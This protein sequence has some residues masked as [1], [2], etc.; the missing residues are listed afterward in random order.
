MAGIV[1]MVIGFLVFIVGLFVFYTANKNDDSTTKENELSKAIEIAVADG[2]LTANEKNIIKELSTKRSLD[3]DEIIKDAEHKI[4]LQ[5]GNSETA[6][7]DPK[8]KNG[9]D[10]EKFIVQKF[11]RK[12]FRLKGWAGDKYVN[13]IYADTTSQP[14][15]HLSFNFGKQKGEFSVECK[16]RQKLSEKGI[17]FANVAQFNRYREFEQ[18]QKHP[19]FIAIGVGGS[20]QAP[21]QLFLVPL[22]NLRSNFIPLEILK[23]YSKTVDSKFFYDVERKVLK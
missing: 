16:W 21:E 1:L 3:Y 19:V 17:E 6:L 10:F 2:V 5:T 14:D 4:A 22:K 23:N 18:Q 7:V 20:G 8:K 9:D 12:A 11:D 15:L 13:G